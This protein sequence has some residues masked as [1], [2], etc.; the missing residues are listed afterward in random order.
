MELNNIGRCR[1]FRVTKLVREE[2]QKFLVVNGFKKIE[3]QNSS[4]AFQQQLQSLRR[5]NVP[6]ISLMKKSIGYTPSWGMKT[7]TISK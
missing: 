3:E 7:A 5:K 4:G 2:T 1:R 6:Y